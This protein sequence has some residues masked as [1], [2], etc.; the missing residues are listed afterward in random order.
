MDK[1]TE[2]LNTVF[3]T[4]FHSKNHFINKGQD[5]LIRFVFCGLQKTSRISQTCLRLYPE[6]NEE[7]EL[8]F[9][10]GLLMRSLLMDMILVL[11]FKSICFEYKGNDKEELKKLVKDFCYM[12]INDGTKHFIEEIFS[13]EKLTEEEK[14]EHAN[15]FASVFSNAFDFSNDKP[16]LKR[17]F[18]FSL[19]DIYK[20]SNGEAFVTAETI[21]SL[22][23]YYSKYEHLSHWTSVASTH[24]PFEQ[25]KGKL[26][27][28]IILLVSHARDLLSIAYDFDENYKMLL[29]YMDDLQKHLDDS[30]LTK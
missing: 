26:D 23:S 8:E 5:D 15:K 17:E 6:M 9:S 10:L 16:K 11:K 2:H 3:F 25:R 29:P 13:S 30:Y 20:Q 12:I 27:T 24:F 1:I 18:R 4:A 14:K 19:T 7:N 21:Y 22:Y 28:A